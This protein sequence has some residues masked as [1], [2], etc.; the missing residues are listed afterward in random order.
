MNEAAELGRRLREARGYVG[1]SQDF[2][3]S[4]TGLRRSAISDI[5]RGKRQCS[6]P[7]LRA[8][9]TLYGRTTDS[10]LGA[11]DPEP[12][13]A[14]RA[15]NRT[16]TALDESDRIEVLRFAEFLRSRARSASYR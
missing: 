4:R 8:L 6:G 1:L 15:L 13:D 3:A 5:E 2:V 9:A 12:D 7:E 11:E 16:V 10:I 14:V